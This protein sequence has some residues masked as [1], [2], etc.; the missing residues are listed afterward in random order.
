MTIHVAGAITS[1]L[2]HFAAVG[3]AAILDEV[4]PGTRFRWTS[5]VHPRCEV[6]TAL[7]GD[8]VGQAVIAH[9]ERQTRPDAWLQQSV[10]G[11]DGGGTALFAVRFKPPSATGAWPGH[12]RQREVTLDAQL[13]SW[14]A[15]DGR[16][17]AALGEPAWWRHQAGRSPDEGASR[18]EMKTRN[19][20]EEFLA[21]RMRPL[22]SA[23]ASRSSEAVVSGL[24]GETMADET[25]KNRADSRTSTG[26]TTPRPTDSAI[27]WCALWGISGFPL[28]HRSTDFSVAAG[29]WPIDVTHPT[30][31]ALPVF[32]QATTW[33]HFRAVMASRQMEGA[34]SSLATTNESGPGAAR[35][36]EW[37]VAAVAHFP[38]LKTGSSSAPERQVLTGRIVPL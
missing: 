16:Y 5:E 15:L 34:L 35:L 18:W 33:A 19:R 28:L 37:G 30:Q 21:Q 9:A 6:L 1:A 8:Q 2:P 12:F 20:G 11:T 7:S 29:V 32:T 22:A 36:Q 26:F 13:Q 14:G 23:V 4:E 24:T 31:A 10:T 3:L 17:L 25:G 38:I 27:A